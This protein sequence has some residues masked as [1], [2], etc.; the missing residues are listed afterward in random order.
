MDSAKEKQERGA[1]MIDELFDLLLR[2]LG[3][4]E[5]DEDIDNELKVIERETI[6]KL[7]RK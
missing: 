4:R 7:R 2:L 3:D 6:K 1:K 5:N